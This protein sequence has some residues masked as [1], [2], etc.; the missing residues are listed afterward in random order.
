M[1]IYLFVW[2]IENGTVF[3][4]IQPVVCQNPNFQPRG[5]SG[6]KLWGC[7]S[8]RV[9]GSAG[10]QVHNTWTTLNTSTCFCVSVLKM[11]LTVIIGPDWMWIEVVALLATWCGTFWS[12]TVIPGCRATV[13]ASWRVSWAKLWVNEHWWWMVGP[14]GQ[15]VLILEF[16]ESPWKCFLMLG[17][18]LWPHQSGKWSFIGIF[19]YKCDSI[20]AWPMWGYSAKSSYLKPRKT[21]EMLMG[22]SGCQNLE[23][24]WICFSEELPGWCEMC[25]I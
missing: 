24:Q 10:P 23:V 15:P 1:Y 6:W 25:P 9:S 18:S 3:I 7:C 4:L 22:V 12:S 17:F 14:T 5:S 20:M 13:A 16:L 8:G 21:K 2:R 11:Q 19:H